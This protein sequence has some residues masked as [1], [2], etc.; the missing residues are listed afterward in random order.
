MILDFLP[1]QLP[2]YYNKSA[3]I[4]FENNFEFCKNWSQPYY[5]FRYRTQDYKFRL[6]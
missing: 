5:F 3:L 6:N 4:N 1:K 2:D